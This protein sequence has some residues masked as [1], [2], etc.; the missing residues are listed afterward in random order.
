MFLNGKC[1]FYRI[2]ISK[3]I[4]SGPVPI[5]S[6]WAPHVLTGISVEFFEKKKYI[7]S[8]HILLHLE[9][10]SVIILE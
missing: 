7:K 2:K 8:I 9:C 4:T 10:F 1:R 5:N 6:V 3:C